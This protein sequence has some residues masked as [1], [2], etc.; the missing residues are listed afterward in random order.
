VE[1]AT[2]ELILDGIAHDDAGAD[3]V[4]REA[5]AIGGVAHLAIPDRG[6]GVPVV[7]P[8]DEDADAEGDHGGGSTSL[9]RTWIAS[10][11]RARAGARRR[12]AAKEGPGC[13]G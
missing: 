1:Q 7:V 12:A 9:E 5:V 2:C 8:S 3:S 11:A 4:E 13:C 10:W 6:I